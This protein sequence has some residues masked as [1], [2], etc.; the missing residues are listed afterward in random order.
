MSIEAIVQVATALPATTLADSAADTVSRIVSG[1]TRTSST[2]TIPRVAL[3]VAEAA[4]FVAVAV[5]QSRRRT[6]TSPVPQTVAAKT[7]T[8]RACSQAPSQR[9]GSFRSNNPRGIHGGAQE[10][11][12]F[13]FVQAKQDLRDGDDRPRES[14]ASS[15]QRFTNNAGNGQCKDYPYPNG[16]LFLSRSPRWP[17]DGVPPSQLRR[18]GSPA[19]QQS[20]AAGLKALAKGPSTFQQLHPLTILTAR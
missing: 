1:S 10:R 9:L 8:L 7:V 12:N 18:L 13:G 5:A 11:R 20:G 6:P 15:G 19:N 14:F 17:S 2:A 3:E 16:L 4:L